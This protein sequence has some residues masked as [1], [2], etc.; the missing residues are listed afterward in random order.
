MQSL[1]M[2]ILQ[3][4]KRSFVSNQLTKYDFTFIRQLGTV[5][6]L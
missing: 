1:K 6:K 4:K 5:W 2:E 3:E